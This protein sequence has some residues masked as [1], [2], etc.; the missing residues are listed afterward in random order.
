MLGGLWLLHTSSFVSSAPLSCS[1]MCVGNQVKLS[2]DLLIGLH[3]HK[4]Q[5]DYEVAFVEGCLHPSSCA[6][7]SASLSLLP[8]ITG[9]SLL[10]AP[11]GSGA[12][13]QGAEWE[14]KGQGG[15]GEGGVG[16]EEGGASKGGARPLMELV[17]LEGDGEEAN[18]R[19]VMVRD[20]KLSE[21]KVLLQA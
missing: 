20:V 10:P 16:A 5:D 4:L 12:G 2:Y 18:R 6:P 8:R 15:G 21:L 14:E 1:A 13:G 7:P 9:P 11:S 17:P 3:F 19:A